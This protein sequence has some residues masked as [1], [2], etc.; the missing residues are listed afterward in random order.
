MCSRIVFDQDH[1]ARPLDLHSMD[2]LA[3]VKG[4][5]SCGKDILASFQHKGLNGDPV[6]EIV[7]FGTFLDED[8]EI[9][10]I[11]P[12]EISRAPAP[13]QQP[14]FP[15]PGRIACKSESFRELSVSG[16]PLHGPH[17]RFA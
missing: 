17:I 13:E 8:Q 11:D 2:H 16:E 14:G 4:G 5:H 6:Q 1:N 15:D 9:V 7:V 10:Y 12:I 3:I